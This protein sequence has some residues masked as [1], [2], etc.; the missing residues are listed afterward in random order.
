MRVGTAIVKR[1]RLFLE[2]GEEGMKPMVLRD[3]AEELE[4]HEST[5]SRVTTQKY[6]HTPRGVF[7]FKFFFS[8]HVGTADGG[9]CSAT[10]IRSMVKKLIENENPQ[11]PMSDNKISTFLTKEG[12]NVARRTVAKYRESMLIPPSNERK[13]L[14]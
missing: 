10:A 6:M 3:I 7:E 14:A 13:R 11:K 1:Q 5:I 9:E 4:M 2:Y 12:I 8:S